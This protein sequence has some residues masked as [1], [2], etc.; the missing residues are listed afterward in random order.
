MKYRNGGNSILN[1]INLP[2]LTE[3]P[4]VYQSLLIWCA[5]ETSICRLS[6]AIEMC[7][8]GSLFMETIADVL[9]A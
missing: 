1:T 2:D 8:D 7:A 4:S 6:L 3:I 9:N 5:L